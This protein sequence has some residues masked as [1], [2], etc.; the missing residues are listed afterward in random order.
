MQTL[1]TTL[2]LALGVAALTTPA[3][4]QS[5]E[6]G[7]G[8]L[9]KRYAEAA[10]FAIDYNHYEDNGYGLGAAV[11]V[12]VAAHLD[13]GAFF[14]HTGIEGHSSDPSNDDFQDLAGYVTAYTAVGDFRPFARATLAYEWWS[15]SD[16]AWYQLDAGS[17]Y[18]VTDRLSVSAE[19]SW[20]EFL[21]EDWNGGYFSTGVRANFWVTETIATSASVTY[22]EGGNWGYGVAAV[23]QF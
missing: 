2:T 11:N 19:V 9:G 5:S 3:F 22:T 10:G 4:A 18:L 16:D 23:F 14:N 8:L 17:E 20:D 13:V 21:A 6:A 7:S 1:N 15:V 12:P